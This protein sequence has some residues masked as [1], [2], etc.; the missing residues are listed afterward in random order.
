MAVVATAEWLQQDSCV[1]NYA[2][3]NHCTCVNGDRKSTPSGGNM[4]TPL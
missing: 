1:T 2:N 4:M 3:R